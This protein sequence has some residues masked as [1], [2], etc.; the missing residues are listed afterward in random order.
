[1]RLKSKYITL[2]ALIILSATPRAF[3]QLT[4]LKDFAQERFRAEL[5]NIFW[6]FTTPES[7]R[8][9]A[10]QYSELLARLQQCA[11]PCDGANE[12]KAA[13][14]NRTTGGFART[15]REAAA[16]EH[17]Q[18]SAVDERS[19][20][21][22]VADATEIEPDMSEE[23]AKA[24]ESAGAAQQEVVLVARNFSDYP[25][26]DETYGP[27]RVDDAIAQLELS[28]EAEPSAQP[29]T[30]LV[31]LP[32]REVPAAAQ[33]FAQ[34]FVQPNFQIRLAEK[35]DAALNNTIINSDTFIKIHTATAPAKSKCN[36]P[37][38]PAAPEAAPRPLEK[39]ELIS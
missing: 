31:I 28:Q 3:E 24:D 14:G 37:V 32:K 35:L 19:A 26:F 25:L 23:F 11:P 17:R 12:I 21:N 29:R 8:T 34:K 10:R 13:R 27:V 16:L 1:M 20:Q 9:D 36:L 30:R 4:D 6:S 7:R 38:A 22:L 39:P 5:R 2:V 33:R 15:T 18:P